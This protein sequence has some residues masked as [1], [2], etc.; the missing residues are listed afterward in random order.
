MLKSKSLST[1]APVLSNEEIAERTRVLLASDPALALALAMRVV[2][3][4][5]VSRVAR[6]TPQVET[7]TQ[8]ALRCAHFVGASERRTILTDLIERLGDKDRIVC[9]EADMCESTGLRSPLLRRSLNIVSQRLNDY[10]GEYVSKYPEVREIG[11][12]IAVDGDTGVARTITF[13]RAKPAS[14]A[15]KAAVRKAKIVAPVAA[16]K[17]DDTAS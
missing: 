11:Y 10:E 6:G 14:V 4:A 5:R 13:A 7:E 15:R 12:T 2:G 1:V 16:E 3:G 9:T 8:R 17:G